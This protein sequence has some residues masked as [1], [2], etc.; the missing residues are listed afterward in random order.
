MLLAGVLGAAAACSESTFSTETVPTG[1][2]SVFTRSAGGQYVVRPEAAFLYSAAPPSG[3]SRSTV[4]TCQVGDY[5]PRLRTPEQLDA[6]DS[7]V[8]TAGTDTA[9]LRPVNRFGAVVYAANPEQR[10]FVPGTAV[11]FS[12]TGA[13]GGFPAAEI[14]SLTPPALS[15]LTPIPRVPSSA[16]PLTL[17]WE[18][19]GDDSSRFEVVLLYAAPGSLDFDQQVVCD[20][21]DDGAGTIRPELL[22]GW[23][24]SEVKL[25]E[26][27]RYRTQRQQIGEAILYLLATFD[28]VPPLVP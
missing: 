16:T 24:E 23:I 15:T 2:L 27:T 11:S 8:F 14:A 6:G 19:V 28:S 22:S 9:I 12:I 25:A 18:P 3:D 10:A 7:I 17:T 5:D 21:R 13:A 1:L 20:W 4:D 26:V